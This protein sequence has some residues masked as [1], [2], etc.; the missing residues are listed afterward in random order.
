MYISRTLFRESVFDQN[1]KL[2][3]NFTMQRLFPHEWLTHKSN[4]S[5][6]DDK[7]K[8]IIGKQIYQKADNSQIRNETV[9]N[10]SYTEDDN[11]KIRQTHWIRK[12]EVGSRK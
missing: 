6:H 9:N 8:Q 3:E 10:D 12:D 2:V 4:Q 1:G 5:S 7:S 11:K